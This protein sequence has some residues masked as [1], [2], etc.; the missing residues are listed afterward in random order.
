M[1]VD[2]FATKRRVFVPPA[3]IDT[4]TDVYALAVVARHRRPG[5]ERTRHCDTLHF[6]ARHRRQFS[7][8]TR[9]G[10]CRLPRPSLSREFCLR[11]APPVMV[12]SL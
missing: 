3:A 6:A 7:R 5:D 9:C 4:A 2:I 1:S 12:Y 11:A 10:D 8:G